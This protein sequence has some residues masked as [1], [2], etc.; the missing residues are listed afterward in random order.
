MSDSLCE[1][2]GLWCA[3]R[4]G[5]RRWPDQ[6]RCR[7]AERATHRDS[8]IWCGEIGFCTNLAA[9]SDARR[10]KGGDK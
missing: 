9:Q 5:F 3:C 10:N 7:F 4:A 8:C 6:E 1:D 2:R